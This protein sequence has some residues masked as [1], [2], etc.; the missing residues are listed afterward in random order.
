MELKTGLKKVVLQNNEEIAYRER[1]GGDK[2]VVLV[3]GNMTSS[4]HWD[5]L[6]DKMDSKY[7]IYA[8]DMRGFGESTYFERVTGI[9]DFSEDLHGFIEALGLK[10]FSLIGWSTGGAVCM[11]YVADHPGKCEKLVLNASA[12]TRGYPFFGTKTDGTPDIEHRLQTIEDV[13]QDPGK[14]LA[15]QGLY[16]SKNRDGLKAVWNALIYTHQQPLTDKYEE[17][18]DDMLTQRN[19]ADV[20]HSLNTFN[21][22]PIHNGVNEGS[23]QAKDITI[24]VLVLRGD[25][26][27]VVTEQMTKEIM[28]DLGDNAT[29]VSLEDMG[30][31]PLVDNLEKL[32][33][34]IETFLA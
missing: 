1:D 32:N 15:M 4:K 23:D 21:I 27:Y 3:H 14:T 22:S 31:S 28:E 29:F 26:D 2:N 5:V 16:D 25:R 34:T 7:K 33:S 9:R 24:P 20:Y 10:E 17:Y 13:E 12:S 19:L 6:I 11:Q 30:H 18:V 8:L